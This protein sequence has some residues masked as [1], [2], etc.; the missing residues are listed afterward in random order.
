M[1]KNMRLRVHQAGFNHLAI[2]HPND[3]IMIL[4]YKATSYKK[5]LQSMI[6]ANQSL[7]ENALICSTLLAKTG[8]GDILLIL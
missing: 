4:D 8:K 6:I 5:T 3:D 7:D 1:S 2:G